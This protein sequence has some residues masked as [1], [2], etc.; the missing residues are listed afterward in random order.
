MANNYPVGFYFQLTFK[1]EDTAFKEVTGISKEFNLEEI[2]NGE[3]NRF[4][5]RLPTIATSQ[6]LILKRGLI[7]KESELLKWLANTFSQDFAKPIETHDIAVSLLDS[8][9]TVSIMW[10][11]YKAY[12]VKYAISDF[13]SQENEIV[14]E[15]IEL[16]YTYFE[17]TSEN[18]KNY[19]KQ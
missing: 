6:N 2:I 3:E 9:E 7:S 10:T 15:T 8:S 4:K 12:P 18:K 17:I 5:Y 16:A 13:N 19:G 1:G 11:F 14:M